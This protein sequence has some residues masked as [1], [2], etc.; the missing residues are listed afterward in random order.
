MSLKKIM[1]SV[2]LSLSMLGS[3]SVTAFAA[4]NQ[5]ESDDMR[6]RIVSDKD[7][8]AASDDVKVEI[9]VE[10]KSAQISGL[11]VDGVLPDALKVRDGSLSGTW[12]TVAPDETVQLSAVLAAETT[13]SATTASTQKTTT[14]KATTAA[15][16]GTERAPK[17]GESGGIAWIFAAM[18]VF[19][20]IAF[21]TCA[22]KKTKSRF[23]CLVFGFAMAGSIPD[24]KSVLAAGEKTES[25]SAS[26]NIVI[27]NVTYEIAANVSYQAPGASAEPKVSSNQVKISSDGLTYNEKE[28]LY[29]TYDFVRGIR[30]TMDESGDVSSFRVEVYNS[31]NEL[32]LSDDITPE[33]NWADENVVLDLGRNRVRV[34]AQY[35]D[36]SVASDEL[37]VNNTVK[38]LEDL[39]I[40]YDD[41]DGDGI[42]NMLED[43]FG[44]DKASDDTDA[45]GI[46]DYN[47]VMVLRT[48]PTRK[49]SDRNGIEDGDEDPDQDGLSNKEEFGLGTDPLYADTDH[50]GLGDNDE[51]TV[52]HTDPLLA[53]TDGDGLNDGREIELGYDPA[54]PDDSFR[55]TAGP[56]AGEESDL[57]KPSVSLSLSGEQVDTLSVTKL[58][59]F[60]FNEDT[61][62]YVG[63]GY[64]FGVDG[65][66]DE[67]VLRFEFD[68]ALLE[69]PDFEPV[70]YY[71]DEEKQELIP[72]E[73][74]VEGN[75][76]VAVTTHFSKYVLLNKK[77]LDLVW[78]VEIKISDGKVVSTLPV[79]LALVIDGSGSMEWNDSDNLRYEA[80]YELIDQLNSNDR[81]AVIGFD[82][83]ATVCSPLTSDKKAAKSAVPK[84]FTDGGTSIYSGIIAANEQYKNQ[85]G[86]T[87]K[88]M[89]V[90][91]DGEDNFYYNYDSL[92]EQSKALGVTIYTVGLGA[93]SSI[94]V[95]LLKKIAEATGG[96]YYHASLASG[97]S[98]EFQNAKDD[99]DLTQDS[100][101]DGICDYYEN[102]KIRLGT[103]RFISTNPDDPDTDHDGLPDGEEIIVHTNNGAVYFEYVS[104]PNN[105]DTDG[106]GLLDGKSIE[107]IAPVE[108]N[109]DVDKPNGLSGLWKYHIDY[110]EDHPAAHSLPGWYNYDGDKN[111]TNTGYEGFD[112]FLDEVDDLA[113]QISDLIDRAQYS[114]EMYLAKKLMLVSPPAA[115][116]AFN[117]G[118][119]NLIPYLPGPDD[120]IKVCAEL[121]SSLLN[122]RCDTKDVIHSQYNQW[123]STFGYNDLYDGVFRI[124]TAGNMRPGKFDFTYGDQEYIFWMWRGDYLNLGAGAEIGF[125][126][127]PATY[128]DPSE[129]IPGSIS[130][131]ILDMLTEF[132]DHYNVDKNLSMP[133]N[134][135][136]YQYENRNNITNVYAWDPQDNSPATNNQW[137]AC[138]FNPDYVLR[139]DASKL[140][141][142]GAID[143]S[144]Q[145]DL[146]REFRSKYSGSDYFYFDSD[147]SYVYVMWGDN[148]PKYTPIN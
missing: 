64:E 24:L 14:S 129:G 20:V 57:V 79:D 133:M 139:V 5:A 66:F 117:A 91:T 92:V 127:R 46:S 54:K 105:D 141:T 10:N 83:Y 110:L 113:D 45:D 94:D 61:Y 18:L 11:K 80:S 31:R 21:F 137:W 72:L 67:A 116:A 35:S 19:A 107:G 28:K 12:E 38:G 41:N 44:T 56:A 98:D 71:F 1:A 134:I 136:L 23:L 122:F 30:G 121:G 60:Y 99:I 85:P 59:D 68:P 16:T 25:L 119:A 8:Y 89:I 95:A 103:G 53:D 111:I 17:T 15:A 128:H 145:P 126:T 37:V 87:S 90:L 140:V 47:E 77:K 2:L 32:F 97:L 29:Q 3:V 74:T 101:R 102:G 104:D 7:S 78:D 132:A 49:D 63:P 75:T 6:V 138:G 70:I 22:D 115:I 9:Y 120:V 93:E 73:T 114:A 109:G 125:Y 112:V 42:C 65:E 135:Y 76:A 148:V 50:D 108:Q 123:Q 144:S 82:N 86:N 147:H 130:S 40:D 43:V 84:T 48:V 34:L 96:K 26:V 33:D 118:L 124:G 4:A 88:K 51:R 62:G 81:V 100:D 27:D 142:I 69:D 146:Y 52:H 55:I 58:P 106:D 36:G 131:E 143:M 39:V 13:T